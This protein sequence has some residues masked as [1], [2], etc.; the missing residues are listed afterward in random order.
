MP[1]TANMLTPVPTSTVFG[2]P[3][4]RVSV[5]DPMERIDQMM[6]MSEPAFFI[7][8]PLNYAMLSY[9]SKQ[10]QEVNRRAAFLVADG[11]PLVWVARWK[12]TPLVERV[13]GS[14]LVPAICQLA[15]RREH[16]VFL[17]G[18]APGVADK[19][20]KR[21]QELFPA[22]KIA[23]TACPKMSELTKQQEDELIDSI[24]N[25]GAR[26]LF[27]ARG[28]PAGELWLAQHYERLGCLSVQIG[29]SLDFIANGVVRAPHWMQK[30]GTEW[31]YRFAQEPT[32]LARRYFANGVF[33]LTH[34]PLD[35]LGRVT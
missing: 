11:M 21:L 9:R 1:T 3:L 29:A 18:A 27:L 28:Q 16:S 26:C 34:A 8:A 14:D 35:V 15:A 31:I 33:F 25:S 19:A 7:T 24:R 5:V 13:A 32:R 20:A 4:S 6:A 23:G 30:T 17:L 22:I 10:L 2:L 12:R